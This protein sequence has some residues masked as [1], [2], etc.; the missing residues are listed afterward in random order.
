MKKF[1]PILV[2]SLAMCFMVINFMPSAFADDAGATLTDSEAQANEV[3][4]TDA[5]ALSA[6][7]VVGI[8]ALGGV[9]AM[10]MAISKSVESIAHQPEAEGKI[11]TTLLLGLVFIETLV[12]Y[13]LIVAILVIF[14]L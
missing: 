1:L 6:A 8:A 4:G 11:R 13:A 9:I 5:K 7:I 2:V 14:V 3:D 10:G 12:I